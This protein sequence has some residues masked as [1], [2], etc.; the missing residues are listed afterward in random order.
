MKKTTQ[1]GKLF[2]HITLKFENDTS[3]EI[4][5][6]EQKSLSINY[7]EHRKLSS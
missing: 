6:Q 5:C 2:D 1:N 4:R 7:T 3:L